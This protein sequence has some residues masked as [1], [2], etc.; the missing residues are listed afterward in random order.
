MRLRV[1][2]HYQACIS[3]SKSLLFEVH[4]MA[5]YKVVWTYG[6]ANQ[7][8]T[9]VYYKSAN[10]AK[11]AATPAQATINKFLAIR[12]TGVRLISVRG[13]N[14]ATPRDSYTNLISSIS[15]GAGRA[16]DTPDV[17]ATSIMVRLH[18]GSSSRKVWFRG[19]DDSFVR[20]SPEGNPI[21]IPDLRTAIQNIQASL[22][23]ETYAIKKLTQPGGANLN[24]SVTS[25]ARDPANE[26]RS[27]VTYTGVALD[28]TKPVIFH[29]VPKNDLPGLAGQFKV[30]ASGAGTITVGYRMMPGQDGLTPQDMTVRNFEYTLVPI[31]EAK[32]QDFRTHSTGRPTDSPRGRRSTVLTRL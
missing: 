12:V 27:I 10:T 11:L 5:D 23:V 7:G 25:I 2:T 1:Q 6:F 22:I 21:E 26:F 18:G 13:S 8:W 28:G 19:A 31:E 32:F 4:G 17:T 15:Q 3:G 16:G 20:R 14:L 30:L 9:E 29:R 24:R